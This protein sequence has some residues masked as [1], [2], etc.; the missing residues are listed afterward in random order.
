MQTEMSERL[1][2]KM[3]RLIRTTP[4]EERPYQM[5]EC[6]RLLEDAGFLI[7][8]P[9]NETPRAFAQ[10]LFLTNPGTTPLVQ[11]AIKMQFNPESAETPDDLILRLLPSDGHL[12]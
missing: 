11:Q 3:E 5:K 9:R 1:A 10:D 6:E 7:G 4:P 2:D 12:D 8:S